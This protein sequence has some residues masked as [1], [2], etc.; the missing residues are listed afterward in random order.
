VCPETAKKHFNLRSS[1]SSILFASQMHL[2]SATS[3]K[4]EDVRVSGEFSNYSILKEVSDLMTIAAISI[5]YSKVS[6]YNLSLYTIDFFLKH[7]LSVVG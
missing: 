7:S 1:M 6:L 4:L 3:G 2:Y 5:F